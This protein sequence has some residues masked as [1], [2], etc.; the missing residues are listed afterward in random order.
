MKIQKGDLVQVI[1]GK[2]KGKQGKVL[3]AI[4]S[5]ERVV[6][7]G[8]NKV[9][10]HVK[11]NGPTPGQRLVTEKSLHV[12]NVALMDPTEKKPTRVGYRIEGGKKV[13]FAKLSGKT[14]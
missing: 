8:A 12:S 14:L 2:D 3:L 11:R 1:A 10:R 5:E 4:P 13:R 9:T 7:E 6:V